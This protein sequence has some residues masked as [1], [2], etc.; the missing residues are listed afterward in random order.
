MIVFLMSK[1]GTGKR[2]EGGRALTDC[3]FAGVGSLL[4]FVIS[5]S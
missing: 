1:L 5:M 4:T 3:G 2:I